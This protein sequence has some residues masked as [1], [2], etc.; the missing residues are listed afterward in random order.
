MQRSDPH[1]SAVIQEEM[2]ELQRYSVEVFDRVRK[3][4]RK[5]ERLSMAQVGV[6]CK[7][8]DSKP[9]TDG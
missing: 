4:Q 1:D 8:F 7:P 9:Q 3:F 6:P 2:D 5:L